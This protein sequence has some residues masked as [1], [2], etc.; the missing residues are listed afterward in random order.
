MENGSWLALVSV[1]G[2]LAS[3]LSVWLNSRG[4]VEVLH[5]EGDTQIRK[6]FAESGGQAWKTVGDALL[7]TM[8]QLADAN[9]DRRELQL[10]LLEYH[11]QIVAGHD[12]LRLV[13]QETNTLL[14]Q[15]IVVS[16]G[17]PS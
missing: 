16:K 2:G 1:L 5:A 4:K 10:A 15:L 8:G 13:L 14:K 17:K 7:K 12:E 11:R 6:H 9:A 3:A